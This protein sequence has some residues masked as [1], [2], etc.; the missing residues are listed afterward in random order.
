M[1][2]QP[3]ARV[4]FK[5]LR[6]E[7]RDKTVFARGCFDRALQQYGVV[8][9]EYRIIDMP[10]IDLELALRILGDG[11]VG[12]NILDVTVVVNIVQEMLYFQRSSG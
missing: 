5:R 12:G 8:T 10:Q 3:V 1:D 7:T 4:F 6:H 11:R 9:G 2:V